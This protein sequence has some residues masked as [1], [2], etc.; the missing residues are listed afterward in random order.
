MSLKV[1]PTSA[2]SQTTPPLTLGKRPE[3]VENK[4]TAALKNLQKQDPESYFCYNGAPKYSLVG[5]SDESMVQHIAHRNPN[6]KDVYIL[7]VGAGR[8]QWGSNIFKMIQSKF[9][10]S[11]T[12]FHII[13]ITGSR[14]SID[15]IVVGDNVRH[16]R[17]NNFKIENITEELKK[18]GF[19]LAN[20]VDIIFSRWTL[21]HL[22]DPAK[23]VEELHNLL[24]PEQGYLLATDFYLKSHDDND[25][26][27]KESLDLELA[28]KTIDAG[29]SST[30]VLFFR[31]GRDDS[32]K[33][34]FLLERNEETPLCLPLAYPE[35]DS[36]IQNLDTIPYKI[37]PSLLKTCNKSKNKK[38]YPLDDSG[39]R[40]GNRNGLKLYKKTKTLKLRSTE[41]K[42]FELKNQS[43]F[44]FFSKKIL[45][46]FSNLASI[47]WNKLGE[48]E[49]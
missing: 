17:F 30:S 10:N 40:Y 14:E 35:N 18:R 31:C 42:E 49:G 27:S 44:T 25:D 15:G 9:P 1:S 2:N 26:K 46:C 3:F 37:D 22:I 5:L 38:I 43:S 19:D 4:I 8:S 29:S 39:M 28:S 13:S 6:K 24:T 48:T 34:E 21:R 23:T 12:Q 11:K 47:V 20:K 36:K 41:E 16:Y 33:Y 7:D 45:G 32:K